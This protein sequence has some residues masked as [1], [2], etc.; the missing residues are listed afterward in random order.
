[1][2]HFYYFPSKII[3]SIKPST[4]TRI[5]KPHTIHTTTFPTPVFAG[6]LV[7]ITSLELSDFVFVLMNGF[8]SFLSFF[9]AINVPL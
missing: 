9:F 1:M 7:T 2:P 4:G 5:V 6:L 8:F 3:A